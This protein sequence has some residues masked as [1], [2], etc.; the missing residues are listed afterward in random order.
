MSDP[1][2]E[3]Q[4]K[5]SG[6][7]TRSEPGAVPLSIGWLQRDVIAGLTVAL[8]AIPQ[9][10]AFATIAGLPAV[11]G[12]YS[13]VV[14]GLVSAALSKS[15]RLV[16]GPAITASTMLLAV[17]RTVEPTRPE[18]WPALAGLLAILVG[19]LTIL[20]AALNVGRL[21][22]FVSRS[23]I[24]G[25]VVGSAI[26]TIGAQLAPALGVATGRQSMLIG[27]L[28]ETLLHAG[29]ADGTAVLVAAATLAFVLL[30]ARLG[31]RFPAP[32]LALVLSGLAAWWL[33]GHG[34]SGALQTIGELHWTWPTR[35]ATLYDGNYSSD[36]FVGACAICLVGVIQSLAI[37]KALALR[38]DEK[39]D[40]RRELAVLGMANVAAGCV[41]GIPGSASFARTALSDL[42][43]AQTRLSGLAAALATAGITIL[44]AP[45]A[46][47]ITLPAI[48]GLLMATAITIVDWRELMHILRRDRQDRL[49]LGTMLVCVFV[50][51]IHWAILIGLA[52]SIVLFLHR[53]SRL[54]LFEMVRG[55]DGAFREHQ[56]DRETG[57]SAITMLQVEGPLFFAHADEL[58]GTL[59][60]IFERRP[61]VVILRMRRTQ[62]IDFSV[63]AAIE[64]VIRQYRERGGHVLICGLAP[65]LRET[66]VGSPLG[67]VIGEERLFET[68]LEVFG[69]ATRAIELAQTI[70]GA[71]PA[72]DR[73]LF[74]A[75]EDDAPQ[76]TSAA[77]RGALASAAST[78]PHHAGQP[79]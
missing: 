69:S 16:V 9:C 27:I 26:L 43:G 60:T 70:V 73:P 15:P 54:H 76:T 11:T 35:L 13:A 56:I 52:A 37:A 40:P 31:P 49:V 4:R 42:A 3:N 39:L 79:R 58:A 25:L 57:Y 28:W 41:H 10:M 62:Q 24:V 51:P 55:A 53:V 22:R 1:V 7:T 14:M 64:R 46:R 23:V 71:E 8:V 50:L 74:R 61:R 20:A 19:V 63:L 32:F 34:Q 5:S 72:D 33:A 36:L 59:G 47:H 67:Q 68:S 75:A 21:V 38:A 78:E 17:L 66:V 77:R 12:L 48:A 29:Q 65:Q 30:G 18:Q 45:L 2:A 44:A 6:A